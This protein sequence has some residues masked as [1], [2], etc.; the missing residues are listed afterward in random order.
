MYALVSIHIPYLGEYNGPLLEIFKGRAEHFESELGNVLCELFEYNTDDEF[1]FCDIVAESF[2]DFLQQFTEKYKTTKEMLNV[3]NGRQFCDIRVYTFFGT[4]DEFIES[5]ILSE[6]SIVNIELIKEDYNICV[7][8]KKD[9]KSPNPAFS[10]YCQA[11]T[12]CSSTHREYS[13]LVVNHDIIHKYECL[14]CSHVF[15]I[16][17]EGIK[18][19]ELP[20]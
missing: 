16:N 14:S 2:S 3:M 12:E 18:V 6:L 20:E 13:V 7:K 5:A 19:F 8:C 10:M 11:C 1:R 17:K 15:Y 9:C 4:A